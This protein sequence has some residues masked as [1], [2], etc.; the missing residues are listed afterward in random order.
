MDMLIEC[1]NCRRVERAD[2][3]D[4]KKYVASLRQGDAYLTAQRMHPI[5]HGNPDLTLR[6]IMDGISCDF[7]GASDWQIDAIKAQRADDE[8][9]Q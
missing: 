4:A 1:R 7:C 6:N 2:P 5:S 3:E 9:D 8:E